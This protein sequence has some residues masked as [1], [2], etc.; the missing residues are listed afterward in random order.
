MLVP[1]LLPDRAEPYASHERKPLVGVDGELLGEASITPPLLIRQLGRKLS[2][3][4]PELPIA[5]V[6][7]IFRRAAPVFR[8]QAPDGL[9]PDGYAHAIAR[10]TG[11]PIQVVRRRALV[12]L[13]AL[14]ENIETILSVQCGSDPRVFDRGYYEVAGTRVASVPRGP[15]V[16]V[17]LPGNNPAVNQIWLT[18][19]AMRLAVVLRPSYA[20]V[21]TSHRLVRALLAA[22]LPANA[23]AF[24]PG[25]HD[26]VDAL[27]AAVPVSILFGG[28]QLAEEYA[29]NRRVKVY[30]PGRSKVIVTAN[31]DRDVAVDTICRLVVDDGGRG[32]INA[33]AVIVEGDARA[34]AEAVAARLRR[35]PVRPITDPDAVL[36][37]LSPSEAGR[38]DALVRT[39]LDNGAIDLSFGR[40]SRVESCGNA[41]VLKPTIAWV[42]SCEH[43]LFGTELPFPF[44][45]FASVSSRADLLQAVGDSLAVVVLGGDDTIHGDLL[46]L[47]GVSK[48]YSDGAL[49]TE[50]DPREPHE[51]FVFDFLFE[52]KTSHPRGEEAPNGRTESR[53]A[54]TTR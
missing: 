10:S 54:A 29:A 46:A 53:P 15:V 25:N 21:F 22:G 28:P 23:I 26:L 50:M 17:N 47:P 39:R 8:D 40:D 3:A 14:L 37:A 1:A 48:V 2:R 38:Y 9:S 7:E 41:A 19:L 52:K 27:V 49:S 45:V 13:P 43:P 20:D 6:F 12:E 16:G 32:C 11:L 5:Q 24:A 51:G 30:G 44:A 35:I 4:R 33:S 34:L 18:V 42:P 31:A 36:P